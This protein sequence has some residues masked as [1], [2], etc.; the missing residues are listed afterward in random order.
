MLAEDSGIQLLESH[1]IKQPFQASG[2]LL[3]MCKQVNI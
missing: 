1:L 3:I 2:I